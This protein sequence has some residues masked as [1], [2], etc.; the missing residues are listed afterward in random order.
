MTCPACTLAADNKPH[1]YCMTCLACCVR[2]LRASRLSKER[3]LAM[4][5][6]I[7]R[8]KGAPTRE[9]ILAAMKAE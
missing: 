5:G 4:L 6:V 1:A 7:E 3:Q 2:L 8:Y 9:A